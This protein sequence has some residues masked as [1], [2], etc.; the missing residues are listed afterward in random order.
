MENATKRKERLARQANGMTGTADV[1][2]QAISMGMDE[3]EMDMDA[4]GS[5]MNLADE[6]GAD[7]IDAK[8][9]KE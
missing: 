3:E 8:L 1:Y 2:E 9:D 7:D 5:Q 6:G 4:A